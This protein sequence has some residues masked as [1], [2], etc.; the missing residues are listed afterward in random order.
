MGSNK[1]ELA[2]GLFGTNFLF[3]FEP[4]DIELKYFQLFDG[5]AVR[6]IQDGKSAVRTDPM[7]IF[8]SGNRP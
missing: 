8:L 4:D 7:L 5:P 3:Q 2:H 1:I 6:I